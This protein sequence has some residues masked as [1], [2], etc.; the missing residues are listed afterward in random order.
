[1]IIIIKNDITILQLHVYHCKSRMISR[2]Y[3]FIATISF[4]DPDVVKLLKMLIS[5]INEFKSI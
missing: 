3:N 2:R 5:L 4:E 1:M